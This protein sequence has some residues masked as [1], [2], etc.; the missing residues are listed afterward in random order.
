MERLKR[1]ALTAG[2]LLLCL[3]TLAFAFSSA[4]VVRAVADKITSVFV[5]NDAAHPVPVAGTL[6]LLGRPPSE[7][8][9]LVHLAPSNA[10]YLEQFP[11]GSS[12][13]TDYVV[14]EGRVLV[15]TDADVVFRRG[16]GEAGMTV[17]YL[18]HSNTPSAT[19]TRL[20][21][22]TTLNV[23]GDGSEGQHLQSGIVL[24]PGTT[25]NDN[26]PV[27]SFGVATLRGYLADDNYLSF[28]GDLGR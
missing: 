12:A 9:T 21:L 23:E 16:P 24:S 19:G 18:L 26:L 27:A 10:G 4:T 1:Y 3:L 22:L 14:P 8:V 11:D 6:T 15:L 13:G 20:R 2:G 5:T 25:L 7:F 28:F 17:N